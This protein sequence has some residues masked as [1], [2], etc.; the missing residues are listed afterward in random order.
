DR[1]PIEKLEDY[2]DDR[3]F[4][5]LV[6]KNDNMPSEQFELVESIKASGR[7]LIDIE[8]DSIDSI[9]QEFFRW[10]FATAVAGS[11]MGINP[12]NQPDVESAKVEARKLTDEC[13]KTG[14]LPD[15]K[16]FFEGEGVKLFTSTEYA[17]TLTGNGEA[18]VPSI[19]RSHLSQIKAG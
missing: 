3:V 13:E 5:S 12:F 16:A 14:S 18:S 11:I 7:P 19:L 1:E 10:E 17:K 6:T 4:V 8:L 15:A 2:S 9:G